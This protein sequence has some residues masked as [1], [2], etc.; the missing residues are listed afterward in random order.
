MDYYDD[1]YDNS[2]RDDEAKKKKRDKA[3]Q[4]KVV[5]YQDLPDEEIRKQGSELLAK[6]VKAIPKYFNQAG[7]FGG[8]WGS[9]RKE[10]VVFAK[11]DK[12][13]KTTVQVIRIGL[14]LRPSV[15]VDYVVGAFKTKGWG[16]THTYSDMEGYDYLDLTLPEDW[17]KRVLC[18]GRYSQKISEDPKPTAKPEPAAEPQPQA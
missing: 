16:A 3:N 5:R 12:E 13:G 2:A 6:I 14:S 15:V 9:K 17:L 11:A 8:R 4:R 18:I 7:A 1:V 10:G